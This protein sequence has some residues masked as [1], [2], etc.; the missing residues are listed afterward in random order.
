MYSVRIIIN[1][2]YKYYR[3]S[4]S[5]AYLFIYATDREFERRMIL[6]EYAMW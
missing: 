5:Y 1:V 4:M 2:H 6:N 3:K